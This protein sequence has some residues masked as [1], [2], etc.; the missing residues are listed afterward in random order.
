[1][2]FIRLE[3]FPIAQ[4]GHL[5]VFLELF[6]GKIRK[7]ITKVESSN[8]DFLFI[9]IDKK[10]LNLKQDLYV[11]T[12]YNP[13]E[14]STRFEHSEKLRSHPMRFQSDFRRSIAGIRFR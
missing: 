13:P 7:H 8:S 6:R 11:G 1:V 5:V 9:K 12:I 10:Y 4:K 14:N 2:L 3:P